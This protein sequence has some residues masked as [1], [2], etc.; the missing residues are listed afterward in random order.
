MLSRPG[1]LGVAAGALGMLGAGCSLFFL[2]DGL[3]G[4]SDPPAGS[5]TSADGAA[6]LGPDGL[7]VSDAAVAGSDAAS[8]GG[9]GPGSFCAGQTGAR[10]CEDFDGTEALPAG[11]EG[12]EERG[13]LLARSTSAFVSPSGALEARLSPQVSGEAIA[14]LSKGIVASTVVEADAKLRLATRATPGNG[15]T[16]VAELFLFQFD[17]SGAPAFLVGVRTVSQASSSTLEL[18]TYDYA[19]S[20]TVTVASAPAVAD[21]TWQALRLR[22]DAGARVAELRRGEGAAATTIAS[23][24]ISLPA[25]LTF[26]RTWNVRVGLYAEGAQSGW[27]AQVDDVVVRTP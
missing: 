23:G 22:V 18:Y 24:P 5:P 13:G 6:P 4:G 20:S 1:W 27:V 15:G 17:R 14:M 3:S 21:G 11:F 19:S 2:G 16:R 9:G 7:A 10:F 25:T 26:P 12:R 8:G